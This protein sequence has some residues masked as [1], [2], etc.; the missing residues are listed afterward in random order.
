MSKDNFNKPRGTRDL[1]FDDY[2]IFDFIFQTAKNLFN[3]Y[4]FKRISTPSF[5]KLSVF[6][7]GIGEDTDVIE[8]EL[9]S[10]QDKKGRKLA[11]KPESTA[12]IAR[13]FCQNNMHTLPM[14]VNI[15]YFEPH[16]RYDRPSKGRYR[17]FYQIGAESI[18]KKSTSLDVQIINLAKRFLENLGIMDLVTLKI[19]TIGDIDSRKKYNSYL[20][21]FYADKIDFLCQNCK[22]RSINNPMRIFDCKN[23]NCKET[24][25][26][27]KN[28]TDFISE[29]SK[30]DFTEICKML[31]FLKI[32]YT[33]DNFL[34]RGLDYYSDL[35]FE[36]VITDKKEAQNTVLGGGRYDELLQKFMPKNKSIPAI[37]FACGVD[38][39][40]ELMKDKNIFK[41]K[42]ENIDVFVI[43]L[44]EENMAMSLEILENIRKSKITAMG[45]LETKSLKSQMRLASK[46]Y[47]KFCIIIGMDEAKEKNVSLKNMENSDQ[48]KVKI[49]KLI[50]TLE[51]DLR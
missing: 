26:N 23:K 24:S 39:I 34:V 27:A 29:T 11:L 2:K 30:K 50:E 28:M 6:T 14:P 42:K 1:L 32:K 47:A 38:R 35:V 12:G 31:D 25:K 51:Q 20:T 13:A 19:N 36:F 8:K 5:E 44:D 10:F 4:N 49:T 46:F 16:F 48:K 43:C 7:E 41:P 18:G 21:D 17:E 15:F 45:C 33:I 40:A 3:V 22:K 9:Y 37:G